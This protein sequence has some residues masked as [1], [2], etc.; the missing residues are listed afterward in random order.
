[1]EFSTLISFVTFIVAWILGTLAKK[2]KFIS[3]N[4]IPIQNICVG[5][6]IA[7]IEY[8]ITKDFKVSIALSGLTAGGIY[9]IFS[10]LKEMRNK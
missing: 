10:N 6:V 7:I 1:M 9:D 4:M 5:V 2:Y 8:I 3:R